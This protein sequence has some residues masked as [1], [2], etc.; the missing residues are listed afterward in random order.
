MKICSKSTKR[1]KKKQRNNVW[2]LINVWTSVN[3]EDTSLKFTTLKKLFYSLTVFGETL[4]C[5]KYTLKIAITTALVLLLS[6]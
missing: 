6:A 4:H 1:Q 3:N 5:Q 2:K